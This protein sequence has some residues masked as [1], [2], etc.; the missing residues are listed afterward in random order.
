MQVC[1]Y[2]SMLNST[3]VEVVLEDGVELG[4][5]GKQ[6]GLSKAT[7]DSQGKFFLLVVLDY[8]HIHPMVKI[9]I[10]KN[11]DFLKYLGLHKISGPKKGRQI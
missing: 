6:V 10:P 1:K 4:N 8:K 9:I 11:F 3:Q 2:V 7:L 5:K